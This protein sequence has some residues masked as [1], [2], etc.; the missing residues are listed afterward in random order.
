M[1]K[2]K[3]RQPRSMVNTTACHCFPVNHSLHSH[4]ATYIEVGMEK[5]NLLQSLKRN[6]SLLLFL[7]MTSV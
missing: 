3:C 2:S 5:Q 1:R 6:K 4:P 7:K